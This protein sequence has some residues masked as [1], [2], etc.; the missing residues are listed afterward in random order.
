MNDISALA[1]WLGEELLSFENM[2][3]KEA[4]VQGLTCPF[5]TPASVGGTSRWTE[6]RKILTEL[7]N[8]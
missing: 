4:K 3:G 5:T 1:V 7:D 6:H 2:G 8:L